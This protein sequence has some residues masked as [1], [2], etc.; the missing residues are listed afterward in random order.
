MK[1]GSPNHSTPT[2]RYVDKKRL[3]DE[4]HLQVLCCMY[5]FLD[6]CD[7]TA[8]CWAKLWINIKKRSVCAS[9]RNLGDTP[10]QVSPYV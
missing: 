10:K 8:I 4:G 9:W 1:A 7:Y 3:K 6:T 5:A 2:A